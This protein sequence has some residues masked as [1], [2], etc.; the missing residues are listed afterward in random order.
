MGKYQIRITLLSDL[1]VSDGGVYNSFLDT[2]ICY[3]EWGFPYIPA[4]RLKGCLRECALELNDWGGTIPIE[5]IFGKAGEGASGLRLGNAYLEHYEE[6][7]AE[8]K[9]YAHTLVCHPQNILNHFS[10]IRTQT[11]IQYDTGV[12]DNT[13]LRNMRV[14]N[15]GLVFLAEAELTEAYKADF[16]SCC[17]ALHAIGIARTR[18]LGEV[19]ACLEN[20]SEKTGQSD[21]QHASWQ[22][23]SDY[24]AYTLELKEPLICK[25][26][27][28]GETR[29]MD[30]IEGSKILGLV[31][32]RMKE[33]GGDIKTLLTQ[34]GEE[35]T[36]LFCSNAYLEQ[37]GKRLLEVPAS[38]YEIK[39]DKEHY[40][41]RIYETEEKKEMSRSNGWQL[42]RMKHCYVTMDPA[43]GQL[44]K[45]E[46]RLEERYHHRRP[47]DKAIGRAAEDEEGNSGF[48][49][50]SSISR[51]QRFQGYLCGSEEQIQKIY[52]LLAKKQDYYMGYSHSAEYG[53]VR[54]CITKVAKQEKTIWKQC[55]DFM[56]KL[57]A[58]TIIYGEK[59]M[60][61]IQAQDLIAEINTALGIEA[62]GTKVERHINYTTLGGYNVTWHAR[63]PVIEAF[64]KGTVLHYQLEQPVDLPAFLLIG[65]RVTEGFGEASILPVDR[66]KGQ[67]LGEIEQAG[68]VEAGLDLEA[69]SNFLKEICKDLFTEYIRITAVQEAKRLQLKGETMKPTVSN[70]LLMC[71]DSQ[72]LGQVEE[73]MKKRFAEKTSEKKRQKLQ[74]AEFILKEV[75]KNSGQLLAGFCKRYQVS[76]YAPK[77]E[78]YE[79]VYLIHYLNELKYRFRQE[80]PGKGERVDGTKES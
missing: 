34:Q 43:S 71:K 70:L 2:E 75:K 4:K 15:K 6:M 48:Y 19:Q 10:Y 68:C 40:I 72:T 29:T 35:K 57:E 30:Y 67:Y 31:A 52:K 3:D 60:Y 77:Q 80:A 5:A 50:M 33:E 20:F 9:R 17:R 8:A 32:Q 13:T 12:A 16:S 27:N 26:V 54:L 66:E 42:N 79:Y 51:G 11:A 69:G 36:E 56:V 47:E 76:Q 61:S 7:Q 22:E 18:G 58:P 44:M 39:N 23:G 25:S 78:E 1:C 21:K 55:R 63:K 41:D 28:G 45:G 73:S 74:D 14:V 65:E 64:E 38:C 49:Q 24:L 37:K 59:A 46:V 53:R 62:E